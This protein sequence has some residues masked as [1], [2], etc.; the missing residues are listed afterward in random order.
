VSVFDLLTAIDMPHPSRVRRLLEHRPHNR[1]MLWVK[2]FHIV[3]VS[4]WFAGL[5]YLPRIFVNLAMVPADSHAERERLLMMARRLY[6]FASLLMVFAVGLGLWLWLGYF[7]GAGAWLHVKLFL[8]LLAIG[9]HHACRSLLRKFEQVRQR[10]QRTLVPRL[11][12]SLGAPVHRHRRAGGRQAVLVARMAGHRSSAAP[13]VATYAALIVYAS[14]YPFTGW[15]WPG[16]SIL[17]FLARP[18]WHWWTWFDVIANLLGYLPLGALVFGAFVRSG[19][20]PGPSI[21]AAVGTGAV[22]SFSMELLQNFLPQRVSSNVDLALN[23]AWHRARRTPRPGHPPDRAAV[24]RWQAVRDRWFIQGSAG[25]LVL[26]VLWPVGL[27]FPGPVPFTFGPFWARLRD[28]FAEWLQDSAAAPWFEPLLY[29]DD[30]GGSLSPGSEFMAIAL[31]LLAP[32]LVAYTVS[33]PGWRRIILAAGAT[34][35]G[36]AGDHPVDRTQLRSAAFARMAHAP[37][38]G[39][40]RRGLHPGRGARL[41]AAPR[42]SGRR[43]HRTGGT[44]DDRG[45]GTGRCVLRRKPAGLGA[46]PLH[47]LP[48]RR[49]V[50]GLALA[51]RVDG[52]PARAHRGPGRG[53]E[54]PALAVRVQLPRGGRFPQHVAAGTGITS[55]KYV[56]E[57]L[58]PPPH[59]LLPEPARQRRS[60]VRRPR[61][62]G[63]VRPLQAAGE[64]EKLAGPGGIRVNKAG[65]LDRCAGG[66]VAVVYPEAVWYTYVDQSDIDEIVDSHLKNG[67]VVERLL[68]PPNVGR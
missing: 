17:A 68:L 7:R 1:P 3:F 33:R 6:R 58:L 50:G 22:L 24:E 59:L 8:V 62:E 2:A 48:R 60:L 40:A 12:R 42:R 13:L 4:S 14:L 41:G 28:A 51:I 29:P 39:G 65:C 46:R 36:P 26:L 27:L 63:R 61:P 45:A 38:G 25:G 37:C 67:K 31:G 52:L 16:V 18:W 49:A 5:F 11:Q 56:N 32:C 21:A 15:R 35:M 57:Q 43:A 66:P 55:L 53:L 34:L 10:A 20:R 44:G 30:S 64:G 54:A 23:V 19:H 47:P 9:Y